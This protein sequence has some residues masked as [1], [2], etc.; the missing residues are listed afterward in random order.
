MAFAEGYRKNMNL[1]RDTQKMWE[2]FHNMGDFPLGPIST[3]S[4][5]FFT[6]QVPGALMEWSPCV[7]V[8]RRERAVAEA[9]PCRLALLHGD[10]DSEWQLLGRCGQIEKDVQASCEPDGGR[11]LAEGGQN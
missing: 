5:V 7:I 11:L 3:K 10:A 4:F 6:N 1:L 2:N 9:E 8:S